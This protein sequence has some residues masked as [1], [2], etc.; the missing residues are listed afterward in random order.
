MKFS[1]NKAAAI[2]ITMLLTLSLAASALLPRALG[3]LP[4]PDGTVQTSYAYLKVGPNPIGVGQ[5]ATIIM[6]VAQPTLTSEFVQNWTVVITDPNGHKETKANLVSDATGGTFTTFTPTVTGNYTIQGFI[7][8]QELH[9]FGGATYIF[10]ASSTPVETLVVQEEAVTLSGYPI[11]P[12]PTQWW[13]T[14]VSAENVQNWWKIAGPW[15]GYG[16][17]AFAITGG[18]NNTQN[19]FNPYTE[20]VMSGHV[21]W[22][23]PWAVGGVVGG[24]A[25]GNEESGHFWS[26]SQY[27]PKFAPVIMNGVIY[28]TIY[29]TDTSNPHGIIAIDLYTGETLWK[30]DSTNGQ[31]VCGMEVDYKNP[32]QYAWVGPYIVTMGY[33]PGVTG[34]NGTAYNLFDALT[35]D[36]VCSVINAPAKTG[37]N[38]FAGPQFGLSANGTDLIAWN[39][40]SSNASQPMLQRFSMLKAIGM[41]GA[42]GWG[43]FPGSIHQ[44]NAGIE[45]SMP[46]YTSVNGQPLNTPLTVNGET[47]NTVILTG[48]FSFGQFYGGLQEGFTYVAGMDANTGAQL[49][50][51]N[52]TQADSATFEPWQRTQMQIFDGLWVNV[53][54]DNDAVFAVNA[55]TGTTEWSTTLPHGINT[56]GYDVFNIRTYNGKGCLIVVGFGGDI[57]CLNETDGAVRWQTDTV[58]LLGNP[59][60]ETPYATWPLWVFLCDCITND[61]GYFAVG[62]EYNPPLFHGAQLIALNMTNGEMIWSTLDM[63]IESTSIAYGILLSRNAYDNQIYAFGKGPSAVT[64]T[65]PDVGVTTATPVTIRGTVMDVSAGAKQDAV[66]ANFPN[67]LPCVSDESQSKWMEYVYQQQ[68][69]PSNATGVPVQIDVIDSNGNYYNIGT[70]TSDSSGTFAFTWTP[71]IPGDFTVIATFGG[72]NSYYGSCAETHFYASEVPQPTPEPTPV[73]Q[74]PV[75]TYFTVSSIAII[76]AIVIV[77]AIIVLM[78]RRR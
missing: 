5:E 60:L 48:G 46:I 19:N 69:L 25:P 7:A 27:Q 50:I 76:I 34:D 77:G 71:I 73:P 14:P 40:D 31:L 66:A 39:I 33:L 29:T 72:S 58:K 36:Y 10:A 49:W 78:L 13:Q 1:E 17:L 44:W 68:P 20:P 23:K 38:P 52:F 6:F 30:L 62:H 57:W 21:L 16:S 65:A 45:W 3:Q 18:Y 75:A 37:F 43:P 64:V 59:G 9:G 51:K 8:E 56:E 55:R 15:L 63:S 35:A 26:T 61:V 42:F 2:A 28:S 41:Q 74:A 24:P 4:H 11:T 47:G 67:G 22:T 32:N 12:L 53:N 54:M 70:A